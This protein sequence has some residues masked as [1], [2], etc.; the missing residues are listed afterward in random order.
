MLLILL[1][2]TEGLAMGNSFPGSG[3]CFVYTDFGIPD[4]YRITVLGLIILLG[5]KEMLLVSRKE[6]HFSIDSIDMGIYP[7]LIC[8]VANFLFAGLEIIFAGLTP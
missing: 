4:Y 5:L 6:D 7:L 2:G 8:F 3:I 1:R